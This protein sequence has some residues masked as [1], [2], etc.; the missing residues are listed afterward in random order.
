MWKMSE[1]IDL[2][3]WRLEIK[4]AE[5]DLRGYLVG[6]STASIPWRRDFTPKQYD[7]PTYQTMR[8]YSIF[9]DGL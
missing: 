7:E 6:N 4:G 3:D 9:G 5:V 8:L 1:L 2:I